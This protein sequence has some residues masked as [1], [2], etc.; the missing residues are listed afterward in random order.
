MATAPSS[1]SADVRA[2][3]NHPV[4]DSDGH[5]VEFEPA[6]VDCLKE[7]GG[8]AVAERYHNRRDSRDVFRWYALSPD[9]RRAQRATRPPW[10]GL[11]T[12][13]T[14]DRATATLPKLLYER[15]DE[16]GMDFTVLYPTLGLFPPRWEDEELRRA[17]CRAINTLHANIF[18]DYA[19][20]MTPVAVIPMHTP[21]EAIEELDYAVRTLGMKAVVLAGYVRRPIPAAARQA[22]EAARYASWLDTLCL[23]SEYDYDPVWAKCVELKVAPTFHSG[24]QDWVG[25]NSISNYMYNH[26]G[27]FAAAGEALCKALFFGGVTRRFPTLKFAFLECGVNWACSLYA[28]LI[29]HWEKRNGKAMENYNPAN[30]NRELLLDLYQRYGGK[31]VEGKL[32]RMAQGGMLAGS[33]EDPATIDDWWR[34]GIEKPEDIQAL[35]VP[36][37][38]FGC[39]ADDP[40][41]ASAFN[42]T[43]NPFGAKLKAV[44]SSD[45][46]HWDVPDMTEVTEEAYELVEE[47]KITEEDFREFVFVHPAKL[48]TDMNPSFFKG[49]VV[50]SQVNRLLAEESH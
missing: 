22:P 29:G 2:R 28:D 44:F 10:W 45:I 7:V 39:E 23:D 49:T 40:L 17:G 35:F 37:F 1:K 3:L 24:A 19:D 11:P 20:R 43:V 5:T 27:H 6:F 38:Y 41:N 16:M 13:N 48:W 50:E 18:R 47:G 30:L 25:R 14:L 42:T 8:T 26:I 9:E 15:L 4:I 21:Q 33:K 32:D 46:G 12:R 34:C 31:M 36:H